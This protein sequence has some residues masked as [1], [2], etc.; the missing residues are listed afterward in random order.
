MEGNI[1]LNFRMLKSNSVAINPVL[2]TGLA[3]L[4]N[5]LKKLDFAFLLNSSFLSKLI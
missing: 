5:G 4:S 2:L 1:K 3:V